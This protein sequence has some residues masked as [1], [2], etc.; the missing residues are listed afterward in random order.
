MAEQEPRGQELIERYREVYGVLQ[1]SEITVE[2]VLRHW[3]LE[4]LLTREL[5]D[6]AEEH[7]WEIFERCYSKLYGELDWLN[8]MDDGRDSIP[9]DVRYAEWPQLIGPPPRTVYEIGSGKGRLIRFLVECGY[10]CKATEVTRERGEKWVE[11]HPNLIWG[12][13]DGVHLGRFEPAGSW[14]VVI[15]D[16]V[17][18]HLHPDDLVD[19]FLGTFEIL[20]P[21]GRYVFSTP[22]RS[23]GPS[24]V[25]AVFNCDTSHG[26]HLKEYT[27]SEIVEAL[28]S[29]GYGR[30][31]SPVRLLWKIQGKLGWHSRIRCSQLYL[32]YLRLMERQ[33][34]RIPR[35]LWRRKAAKILRIL[36][37]S[38][39]IWIVA[40]KV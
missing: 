36:L 13:S 4:K 35:Q 40:E 7:R 22:H 39:A 26:M 9:A 33:I 6:S 15:S 24:D 25:S 1:G 14:D 38:P 37:F 17:I 12:N 19:H 32:C 10:E 5:L 21:G 18:E 29:A 3:E 30:I 28:S 20:K 27:Y 11:E 2:M 31:T 16:Q 34:E 23:I 8:R